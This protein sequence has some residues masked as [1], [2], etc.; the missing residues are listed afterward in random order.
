MRYYLISSFGMSGSWRFREAKHIIISLVLSDQQGKKRSLHFNDPRRFGNLIFTDEPG[1]N[2]VLARIG[3]DLIREDLP[4]DDWEQ[5]LNKGQRRLVGQFLLDQD[6][7]AGIGNYLRSDILYLAR[8]HPDRKISSLTDFEK[9][10]LRKAC[11][12]LIQE[13]YYHN[14]HTMSDYILPN[15]DP[16]SYQCYTYHKKFCPLN[17]SIEKIEFRKRAVFIVPELQISQLR[18]IG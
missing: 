12:A 16:G 3:R 18:M 13:S 2:R 10:I 15:G 11:I 14:G 9:E 6:L 7:I 17:Y 1:L 5:I 8:L 4:R